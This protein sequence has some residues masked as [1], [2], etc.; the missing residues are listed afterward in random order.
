MTTTKRDSE[1]IRIAS[2][3]AQDVSNAEIAR[4][5]NISHERVRQILKANGIVK[6]RKKGSIY[7]CRRDGCARRFRGTRQY[8][9][10]K[11]RYCH[12]HRR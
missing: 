5:Y 8:G 3:N 11:A 1:I 10:G 6:G 7:M 9:G 12:K 4:R 2:Q